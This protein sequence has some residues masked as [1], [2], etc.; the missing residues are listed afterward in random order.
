M[1][2]M[3]ARRWYPTAHVRRALLPLLAQ[4]QEE[5]GPRERVVAAA[6]TTAVIG[7]RELVEQA[8]QERAARTR[9]RVLATAAEGKVQVILKIGET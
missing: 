4:G 3:L 6:C 1:V 8:A 2:G 7:V 9:R 5:R